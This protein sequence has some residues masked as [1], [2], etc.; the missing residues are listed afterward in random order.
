MFLVVWTFSEGDCLV[1]EMHEIQDVLKRSLG[2]KAAVLI[3][4]DDVKARISAHE[5]TSMSRAAIL[6]LEF[7]M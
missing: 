3:T 1:L 7:R 4:G 6:C 2:K 5:G